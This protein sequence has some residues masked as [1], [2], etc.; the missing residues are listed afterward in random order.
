VLLNDLS[1]A[2]SR[3]EL[4]LLFQPQMDLGR[5]AVTGVEVLIRWRHPTLGE[6]SPSEF[7]PL[8]ES[9][10]LIM[11]I[12]A[13][14]IRSACRQAAAW[15][16]AGAP[17]LTIAVNVAPSQLHGPELID[18]I[19]AALEDHRL[20][21]ACLEIELTEGVLAQHSTALRKALLRSRRWA[22]ASRSTILAPAI[23]R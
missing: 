23:P 11:P 16:T 7:I 1:R 8:A 14:V 17:P 3:G 21:P 15:R 19:G 4:Y 22:C 12:G 6:I 9:S 10:G 2:L 20:A 13:W 18:V 5:L